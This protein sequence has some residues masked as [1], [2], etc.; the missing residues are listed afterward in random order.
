MPMLLQAVRRP[1]SESATDYSRHVIVQYGAFCLAINWISRIL[2]SLPCSVTC[3]T[4]CRLSVNLNSLVYIAIVLTDIPIFT[5][6]Q[7]DFSPITSHPPI[8]FLCIMKINV[9][10]IILT[11]KI[12]SANSGSVCPS[13]VIF[14]SHTETVQDIETNLHQTIERCF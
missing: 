14:V 1:Q 11:L 6:R 8:A 12:I 10:R 13:S 9:G 4:A 5:K 3:S 7:R 2:D